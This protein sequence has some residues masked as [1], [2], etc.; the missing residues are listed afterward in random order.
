L[1]DGGVM[2][3][4]GVAK[5]TDPGVVLTSILAPGVVRFGAAIV[6][7]DRGSVRDIDGDGHEDLAIA[8]FASGAKLFVWFGGTIPTGNATTS[9]AS[10]IMPGPSTFAFLRTQPGA[11]GQAIWIGDT[12]GD[13][14]DD[15]CWSA[16]N[17]NNHN[18]SFQLLE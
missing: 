16:P 12:N 15:I 1:I 18:G 17:D 9:S 7:G 11:V 14:L 5:T 2:G 13:G 4:S 10:Y 3:T 6:S 8:G